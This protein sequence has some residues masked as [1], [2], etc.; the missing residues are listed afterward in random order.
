MQLCIAR[1]AFCNVTPDIVYYEFRHF[2]GEKKETLG[3]CHCIKVVQN[4]VTYTYGAIV[5]TKRGVTL[6]TK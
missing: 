1:R 6:G 2:S 3:K 5:T 4:A